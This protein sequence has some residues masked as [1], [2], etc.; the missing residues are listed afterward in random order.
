MSFYL[1]GE[2]YNSAPRPLQQMSAIQNSAGS[3]DERIIERLRS[4]A[5]TFI[6]F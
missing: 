2:W 1:T 4:K 6:R 3:P 5:Q